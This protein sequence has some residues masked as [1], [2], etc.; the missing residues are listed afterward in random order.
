MACIDQEA[1]D[2]HMEI[3]GECPWCSEY[4]PDQTEFGTITDDG[5]YAA[6]GSL[7]EATR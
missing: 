5:I 2:A 1:H 6:D 4:N 3:N 7:I